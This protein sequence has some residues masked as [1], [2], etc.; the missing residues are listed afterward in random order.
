MVLCFGYMSGK[1]TDAG[2]SESHR[3]V[4]LRGTTVLYLLEKSQVCISW[5]SHRIVSL[6]E[7]TGL[8]LLENSQDCIS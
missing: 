6:G 2:A 7:V 5:K 3:F 1:S 4:Y 8:Y